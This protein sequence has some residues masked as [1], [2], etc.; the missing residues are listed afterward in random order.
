MPNPSRAAL[1]VIDVQQGLI[2]GPPL[3]T[4]AASL[5]STINAAI[6]LARKRAMPV[7]FVQHDGAAGSPLAPGSDTWQLHGALAR[8]DSDTVISKTAADAFCRTSLKATLESLGVSDLWIAGYASDFC[9]D[10]TVRSAAMQGYAVT[11]IAD[12]H[13]GKDRPHIGGDTLIG[14]CNW[15]WANLDT[16]GAP[17]RVLPLAELAA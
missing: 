12:A 9:V 1:L 4:R 11:V 6:S 3:V 14:H 13:A 2:D 5:I 10:S 17:V 15:V 8:E 7:I 16:P